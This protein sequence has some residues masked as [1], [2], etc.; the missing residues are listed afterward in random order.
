[1]FG[2]LR[3]PILTAVGHGSLCA[4]FPV[5]LRILGVIGDAYLGWLG[6]KGWRAAV[7]GKGGQI[8]PAEGHGSVSELFR[9]LAVTATN[10]KV[11]PLWASALNFCR[12]SDHLSAYA[13]AIYSRVMVTRFF[14]DGTYGQ[15]FSIGGGRSVGKRFQRASQA[16]FG[17][18]FDMLG[19]FMINRSM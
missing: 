6:F 13:L 14:I 9:G 16:V 18:M 4:D 10:P 8:I 5:L 17:S 19:F 7:T 15:I 12:T 3:W 2:G 11:A 1:M